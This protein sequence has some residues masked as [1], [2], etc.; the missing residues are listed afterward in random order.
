MSKLQSFAALIAL[1]LS[2]ARIAGASMIGPVADM[3]ISNADITPD[4]Y[5]RAAVVVN[6]EMPGPIVSGNKVCF[7]CP[8]YALHHSCVIT[9]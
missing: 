5:T 1:S 3:V 8:Y 6:G 7:E 2:Y 9:G 4:G